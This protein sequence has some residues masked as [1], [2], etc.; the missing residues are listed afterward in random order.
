MVKDPAEVVVIVRSP[1]VLPLL[2]IRLQPEEWVE[3]QVEVVVGGGG[4]DGAGEGVSL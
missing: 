3:E 1:L 2:Q 4:E